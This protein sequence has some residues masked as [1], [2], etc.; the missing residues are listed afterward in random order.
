MRGVGAVALGA[1]AAIPVVAPAAEPVRTVFGTLPDGRAVEEVTLTNGKGVTA[2]VISWGALL[3]SLDVPDRA[4]KPADIV[5]GYND[6]AGYLA[7]P[8]YFGVSV[9]R[10]ANRIRGGRFILDGQ[11]Y[12]LPTNDGP[13]TLHGGNTGF[14]KRL[15]TITEVKGGATPSVTLRYVS[16][17][18][19]E[20]FPGTLTVTATYALDATNTLTISYLA[21]TDKPTIVNLTN[22]SFFNL[23]GE[24]SGRPVLDQILTIPA[25]RY[26][27]VDATQIPTG[28]R[29]SV[30]GTPFDFRKPTAIGARIRDGRDTQI[31]R[32][33]GYDH[34]WVVTD[35]PT[36]EPHLVARVE[37]PVSGRILE[38]ASNQPGVQFYTGNFIDATIVG[39]SGLVYRQSDALAIEPELFPDTPNQPAFG[40][41]RLDPSA[42]YRNVITYRF[43]A[44]SAHHRTTDK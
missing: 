10:Y 22:H 12:T 35:A 1:C 37:D 41:A 21:T 11:T 38:V 15:W 31:V 34:N 28:E 14:D 16:P 24:G 23:A 39:K 9:G 8:N 2:R 40:S 5:L 29:V 36:A 26:T 20:G 44:S 33:R 4:G 19:E 18:G 25:E 3:R 30:A 32:G 17:D 13:N 42:T 7:Q 27:P 43:S 6:L